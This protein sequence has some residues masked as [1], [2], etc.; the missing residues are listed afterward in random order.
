M[1]DPTTRSLRVLQALLEDMVIDP[2]YFDPTLKHV[3]VKVRKDV[4]ARARAATSRADQHPL[5][6]LQINRK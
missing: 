3:K 2:E 1:I 5:A 6:R 4:L